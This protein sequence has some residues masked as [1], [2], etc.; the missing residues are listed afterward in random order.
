MSIDNLI[1]EANDLWKTVYKNY[2]YDKLITMLDATHRNAM[3][4]NNF[5]SSINKGYAWWK[6]TY[7]QEIGDLIDALRYVDTFDAMRLASKIKSN[8]NN[9][10][11]S[12]DIEFFVKNSNVISDINKYF[13]SL[14]T[15]TR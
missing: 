10:E 11:S 2:T 6:Q 14:K 1:K 8:S 13:D 3:V 5:L 4:I 9:V 12:N 15:K 7:K